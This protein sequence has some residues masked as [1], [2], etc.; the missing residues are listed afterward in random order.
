ME[1]REAQKAG[2]AVRRDSHFF[3]QA[4]R[5]TCTQ[6]VQAALALRLRQHRGSYIDRLSA[7]VLDSDPGLLNHVQIGPCHHQ[8][9]VAT[10]KK[11]KQKQT[12]RQAQFI[13]QV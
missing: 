4:K 6:V 11:Q 5:G 3:T 7:G 9:G 13:P 2:G 1:V 8:R 12:H 10:E